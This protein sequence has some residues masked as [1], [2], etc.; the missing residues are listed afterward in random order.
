MKQ[1]F[2]VLLQQEQ[3]KPTNTERTKAE[4]VITDEKQEGEEQ[5]IKT[6]ED[7]GKTSS[8]SKT[9]VDTEK[10][11]LQSKTTRGDQPAY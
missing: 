8:G 4:A 6:I 11:K 10:T 1:A 7:Q 3:E 2:I 9:D 5:V